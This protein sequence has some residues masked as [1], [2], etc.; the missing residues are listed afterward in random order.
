[1]SV[2]RE[3]PAA[4]PGGSQIGSSGPRR[5]SLI[6]RQRRTRRLLAEWREKPG[7]R[8]AWA[9][10]GYNEFLRPGCGLYA[11]AFHGFE[12]AREAVHAA[13]D[14]CFDGEPLAPINEWLDDL[15]TK[16][17]KRLP[18]VKTLERGR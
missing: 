14:H 10:Q 16:R 6:Y 2:S 15:P 5:S 18:G 12:A 17:A 8:T 13:V 4:T 3:R 1:M 11:A 9:D 7:Q